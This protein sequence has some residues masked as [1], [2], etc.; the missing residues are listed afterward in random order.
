MI[1]FIIN[2][3]MFPT[4]LVC[5]FVH[6]SN[7]WY[8]R[9]PLCTL[10]PSSGEKRVFLIF[11]LFLRQLVSAAHQQLI[12]RQEWVW[13]TKD[14]KLTHS[15]TRSTDMFLPRTVINNVCF[16][17]LLPNSNFTCRIRRVGSRY[18]FDA[19]SPSSAVYLC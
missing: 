19:I 10:L 7:Y 3:D 18:V 1:I 2:K 11:L 9:L 6:E 13:I 14:V 17:S 8:L 15:Q 12:M 5:N 16:K 4:F